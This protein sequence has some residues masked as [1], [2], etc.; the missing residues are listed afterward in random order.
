MFKR[1]APIATQFIS[2][3]KWKFM[4]HCT[5]LD[6]LYNNICTLWAMYQ[7]VWP[8]NIDTSKKN[9]TMEILTARCSWLVCSRPP[10]LG[11]CVHS[12][13]WRGPFLTASTPHFAI[14]EPP[15]TVANGILQ[16][17]DKYDDKISYC[18]V[19]TVGRNMEWLIFEH[20]CWIFY[21]TGWLLKVC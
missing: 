3:L 6:E 4:I 16:L 11:L 21:Y 19:Y 1:A 2:R 17:Y 7:S 5:K 8:W 15:S 9:N 18:G 14:G 20:F 10:S 13:A 12:S